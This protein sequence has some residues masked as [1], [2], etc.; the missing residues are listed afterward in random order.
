[1]PPTNPATTAPGCDEGGDLSRTGNLSRTPAGGGEHGGVGAGDGDSAL[2]VGA[3][4][5]GAGFVSRLLY[6]CSI[7]GSGPDK[8]AA[9]L[10]VI[11]FRFF[12]HNME[13]VFPLP[14]PRVGCRVAECL[15]HV[16]V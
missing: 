15:P 6:Q 16:D 14:M 3:G 12:S 8:P 10:M 1:M 2:G 5:V 4:F 7:S 9:N 13:A 11:F